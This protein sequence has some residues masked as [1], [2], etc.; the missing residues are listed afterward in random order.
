MPTYPTFPMAVDSSQLARA[1]ALRRAK[2]GDGYSQAA[3]AGMNHNL[4]KFSVSISMKK[5]ADID[6][7]DAFLSERG[8]YQMFWW[9]PPGASTPALFVCE[10][11]SVDESNLHAA[12]G[13][14]ASFEER[15]A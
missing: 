3:P 2:F 10:T 12:K 15:V 13:L 11:W 6:A 8:G 1:P 7:V 9:T 14:S 4:R 5:G